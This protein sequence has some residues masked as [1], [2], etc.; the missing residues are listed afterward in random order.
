MMEKA[1][2]SAPPASPH[3]LSRPT[4]SPSL[5]SPASSPSCAS[6]E[7]HS[8][9]QNLASA[10]MDDKKSSHSANKT[11]QTQQANMATSAQHPIILTRVVTNH[12]AGPA[13]APDPAIME[14]K[15]EEEVEELRESKLSSS[16]APQTEGSPSLSSPP[17]LLPAPAK[18][19]PCP[20]PPPVSAAPLSSSSS[21]LPPY[22]PVISLGH[23]KPPL[24]LTSTPLTAL[25][26]IPNL[27]HG[28]FGEIW[29][30]QQSSLSMVGPG[31]AG[32]PRGP[33]GPSAAS[34]GSLLAQQYLPTHPFLTSS[35]LGPSGGSYS[36]IKRR[37]SSHF[38]MDISE[39]P[40]QKLARRVFT[41]SRERWRQQNV[42]G[43]FSELRK[44]IPTH[45]P[46][47]KLSK[48]E[49]LRLAVK[50]INFLVTMLNDQAQDKN[51]DSGEDDS[52][53]E[54]A[55]AGP[56]GSRQKTLYQYNTP[57][58]ASCPVTVA[59]THRDSTDSVIAN[60]P[61]TSSCYGDTDSEGSF[62]A[63]TSL[64]T[65]GIMGKVKGQIGMVAA[66]NDER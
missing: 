59:T 45:P 54:S 66:T 60:S 16:C 26:P 37:P 9:L 55:V 50:Y 39:R 61:A 29:R 53:D 52:G 11:R 35:Y 40:P 32:L 49:I 64:V 19:S 3:D 25:H 28:A 36:R 58:A 21:P 44:L 65:H 10:S 27:I 12:Q 30:S 15:Q 48:N 17:P 13:D 38:E 56:G 22:I 57:P 63:K 5:S 1:K 33:G 46:D 2:H 47:K 41:N 18:P 4:S 14:T 31:A 7:Q 42:N 23:S 43:A 34:S 8:P 62:G 51:R 20:L 6:T 24:P